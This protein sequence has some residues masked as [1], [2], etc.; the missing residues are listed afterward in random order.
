MKNAHLRFLPVEFQQKRAD[1]TTT[2]ITAFVDRLVA[3]GD[4]THMLSL[5]G[6]DS[7]M[8]AFAAA[9]SEGLSFGI[10]LPDERD[11]RLISLGK[12]A[13]VSKY[14]IPMPGRKQPLRHIVALS[15][16]CHAANADQGIIL[17]T[18]RE[19]LTWA[20]LVSKLGLP[21][22]PEWCRYMMRRLEAEDRIQAM[23]GYRC[24]PRRITVTREEILDWIGAGVREGVL[25][26]PAENG[27][28]LWPAYTM[29]DLFQTEDELVLAEAA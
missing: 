5:S 10:Q 7:V 9:I 23:I 24:E 13:Y 25:R 8:A 20:L 4:K 28:V 17:L 2:R 18:S 15:E 1:N 27:P 21:A 19:D 29:A 22:C 16:E 14:S 6:S 12:D 3:D 11:K 26:L